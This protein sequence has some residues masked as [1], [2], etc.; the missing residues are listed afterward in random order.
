[1]QERISSLEPVGQGAA[2]HAADETD[3]VAIGFGEAED[4]VARLHDHGVHAETGD[5]GVEGFDESVGGEVDE[6]SGLPDFADE[7]FQVREDVPAVPFRAGDRAAGPA[8]I[9]M[10]HHDGDVRAGESVEK[11]LHPFGIGVDDAEKPFRI[12]AHGEKQCFP[13]EKI[14][15][16]G[17]KRNI[18]PRH[19]DQIV[20]EGGDAAPIIGFEFGGEDSGAE[21][22]ELPGR[23]DGVDVFG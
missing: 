20:A 23:I 1:M 5:I 8:E 16:A 7:A 22:G 3:A 17:E 12:V 2:V 6:F 11:L 15:K 4:V 18:G 21:P 10:H 19:V 13:S 14:D 9:V